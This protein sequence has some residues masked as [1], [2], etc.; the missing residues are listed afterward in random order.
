MVSGIFC[1]FAF[2]LRSFL[3]VVGK[4]AVRDT[5]WVGDEAARGAG[6][7]RVYVATRQEAG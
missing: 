4:G 6:E 3:V 2:C 5:M 1:L 7:L